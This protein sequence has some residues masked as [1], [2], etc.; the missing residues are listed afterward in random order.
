MTVGQKAIEYT[1]GVRTYGELVKDNGGVWNMDVDEMNARGLFTG[2]GTAGV[3]LD[4]K[5]DDKIGS[6][7]MELDFESLFQDGHTLS[8]LK[9]N[10]NLQFII[11]KTGVAELTTLDIFGEY[12]SRIILDLD[13]GLITC[14][15]NQ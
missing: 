2:T 6:F 5:G 9:V 14:P 13:N 1:G 11:E 15:D 10:N 4:G 8:G 3:S 12:S 7:L